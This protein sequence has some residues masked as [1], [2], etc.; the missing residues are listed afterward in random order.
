MYMLT[1][2][3]GGGDMFDWVKKMP[4]SPGEGRAAVVK[5]LFRQFMEGIVVSTRS[6][7]GVFWGCHEGLTD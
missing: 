6:L 1:P 4:C 2:F 3:V 5:P 7:G